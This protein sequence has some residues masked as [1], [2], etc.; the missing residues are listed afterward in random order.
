MLLLLASRTCCCSCCTPARRAPVRKRAPAGATLRTV[1]Y[2][3]AVDERGGVDIRR[4]G[5]VELVVD[6]ASDERARRAV[7]ARGVA[8]SIASRGELLDAKGASGRG[9]EG[10]RRVIAQPH[11]V[12]IR[13]EI[14]SASKRR[15]PACKRHACG[16]FSHQTLTFDLTLARASARLVGD[17]LALRRDKYVHEAL[18]LLPSSPPR[19]SRPDSTT[20]S[21]ASRRPAE[22]PRL[23]RTRS[24]PR[25]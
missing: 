25:A 19:L 9:R 1:E 21:P 4:A 11:A 23:R 10:G 2:L 24:G 16:E 8:R 6:A 12:D 17:K 14:C 3:A 20:P 15:Q 22:G 13:P 7:R 5:E 18:L